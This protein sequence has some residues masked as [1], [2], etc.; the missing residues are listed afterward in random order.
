MCFSRDLRAIRAFGRKSLE[1][2]WTLIFFSKLRPRWHRLPEGYWLEFRYVECPGS[3]CGSS[4]RRMMTMVLV[5]VT[6]T[7][8]EVL[9]GTLRIYQW[10]KWNGAIT[11]DLL[12]EL[13]DQAPNHILQVREGAPLNEAV[14]G[15]RDYACG[16]R[17]KE[18]NL[19]G[20][21]IP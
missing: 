9:P 3:S 19:D 14:Y 11:G 15:A 16:S 1:T 6:L 2:H 20:R 10:Q 17:M 5:G 13:L 7:V 18:M 21:R 8:L 12:D 4:H